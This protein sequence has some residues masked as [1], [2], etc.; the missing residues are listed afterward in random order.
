MEGKDRGLVRAQ[1]PQ[2]KRI[3]VVEPSAHP[4]PVGEAVLPTI[5]FR[6]TNGVRDH[7][8]TIGK[9]TRVF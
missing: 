5:P 2:I 9:T 6:G 7:A 4:N 1:P 8:D 3:A